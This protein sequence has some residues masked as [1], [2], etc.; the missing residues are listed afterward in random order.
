MGLLDEAHE[1][2][3]SRTPYQRCGV[4][5]A[6][7]ELDAEEAAELRM[8]VAGG[9]IA[10]VIVEV[11]KRRGIE[12]TGNQILRSRNGVTQCCRRAAAA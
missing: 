3:A 6:C 11:L 12:V 10:P 2:A 4:C 8:L 1:V 5:A 9:V 7:D